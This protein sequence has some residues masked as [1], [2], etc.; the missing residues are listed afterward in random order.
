[1]LLRVKKVVAFTTLFVIDPAEIEIS[2]AGH[3]RGSFN[4]YFMLLLQYIST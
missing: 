4:E 2:D 3:V 1:M